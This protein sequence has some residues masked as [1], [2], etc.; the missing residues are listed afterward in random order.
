MEIFG[1]TFDLVTGLMATGIVL[2]ILFGTI[3]ATMKVFGRNPWVVVM[4]AVL[5]YIIVYYN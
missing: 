4:L 3:W 1:F 2:G 5:A